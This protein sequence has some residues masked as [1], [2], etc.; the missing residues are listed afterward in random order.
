MSRL[1]A[2]AILATGIALFAPAA[3]GSAPSARGVRVWK[4]DYIAHDGLPRRAFVILPAWYGPHDHPPLPL[5]ISPHGRGVPASDNVRIWGDLPALGR[6]AVVNPEGQGRQLALYS[7]GD[8][9]EIDDLARM[10]Q[11]VTQAL[12]WLRIDPHQIYAFGGSM[13]GQETLLLVARFPG[14]LAGAASFD[15]P[16]R[17]AVRYFDFPLLRFG[18]RLQA[19]ARDEFGGTPRTDPRAYL[20][21][22]PEDWARQIA[23]SGVPLQIW[24]STTDRIV[25]DQRQESGALYRAIKRLNPDAPVVQFVGTWVHTA[26][27]KST[28]RLPV[29]LRYFGLMPG[30]LTCRACS[31]AS[32]DPSDSRLQ[33]RS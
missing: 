18:H 5:I 23:F 22:S 10:P 31:P 25:T 13:G 14:L 7:W 2:A 8:P 17:M 15:A 16:T 12:S 24:W 20:I 6:F 26:E 4:I 32:R 3:G 11:I 9:G 30:R 33:R 21:R 1:R 29:A 19:L 27:M 28:A